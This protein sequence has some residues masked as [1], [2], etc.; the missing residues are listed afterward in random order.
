M[1]KKDPD[2]LT[3]NRWVH[4]LPNQNDD[5]L[6][7]QLRKFTDLNT[8]TNAYQEHIDVINSELKRRKN[9]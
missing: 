1:H 3:F 2:L 6:K 7:A 5:F 4:G 8:Q 9:L